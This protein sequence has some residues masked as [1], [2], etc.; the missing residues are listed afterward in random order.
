MHDKLVQQKRRRLNWRF[1]N[2]KQILI[3]F[4][5]AK[6]CPTLWMVTQFHY[7]LTTNNEIE[8]HMPH[9][10]EKQPAVFAIRKIFIIKFF[11]IDDC[12]CGMAER[13]KALSLI[14]SRDQC[15]ISHHRKSPT[16]RE[17]DLN[18][19]RTLVQAFLNEV[20]QQS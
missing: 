5:R 16:S 19:R 4:L 17:Q 20:V 11:W 18:L 13:R 12:F 15:Q 1:G 3:S 14:S 7:W 6:K 10:H 8:I 2:N 9:I